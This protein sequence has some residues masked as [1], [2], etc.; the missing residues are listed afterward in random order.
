M[1]AF[2]TALE[3]ATD[4]ARERCNKKSFVCVHFIIS[5]HLYRFEAIGTR[6]TFSDDNDPGWGPG[7]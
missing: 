6:L 4:E 1:Q 3:L 2:Q 7:E 5:F